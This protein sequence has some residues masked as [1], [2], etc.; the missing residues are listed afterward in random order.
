MFSFTQGF[1]VCV[2]VCVLPLQSDQSVTDSP[3]P[4]LKA[5]VFNLEIPGEKDFLICGCEA[6]GAY[7]SH[8]GLK[9]WDNE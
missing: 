2:C 8:R 3:E 6:M 4:T 1:R 7:L 5:F 9:D